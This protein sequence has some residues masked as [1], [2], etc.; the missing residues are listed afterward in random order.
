MSELI[1]WKDCKEKKWQIIFDG[2]DI[3]CFV[4]LNDLNTKF[5]TMY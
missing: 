1:D 5:I 3:K 4:I 2:K